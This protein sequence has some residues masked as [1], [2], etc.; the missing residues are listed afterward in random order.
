LGKN[1]NVE[2]FLSGCS[3]ITDGINDLGLKFCGSKNELLII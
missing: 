1:P 3:F 2:L